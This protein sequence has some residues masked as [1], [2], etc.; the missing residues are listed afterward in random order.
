[1]SSQIVPLSP[2]PQQSLTAQLEVNGNPLTLNLFIYWH[3]MSGYWLMNI[4]DAQGNLLLSGI[5][6]ITGSYPAA[7]ILGQYSYLAI[8]S[9]YL[10]NQSNGLEDYPDSTNLGT[11]FILIWGDNE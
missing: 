9:A 2:Q 4:S 3:S 10:L 5:P 7:N 11:A 1:M 8:G 6:M